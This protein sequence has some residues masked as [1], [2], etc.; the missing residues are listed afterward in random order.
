MDINGNLSVDS[1]AIWNN[2]SISGDLYVD[3]LHPNSGKPRVCLDQNNRLTTT[4]C[5]TRPANNG[6]GGGGEFS[7]SVCFIADTKILM[8]D[9]IYKNIQDV[10]IGD[11][12][13]GETTNN[14][15]LAFHRPEKS[16]GVIYGF[17]GEKAFVTAEHPFKTTQGWK[18]INPEKT[19]QENIGITV[20]QLSV[21]DTLVTEKGN[22]YL[23]SIE[24]E[25]VSEATPLYN[26]VLTGDRTYFADGYLVH[27]KSVCLKP[28]DTG[29]K[30]DSCI[31]TSSVPYRLV[32]GG[33]PRGYVEPSYCYNPGQIFFQSPDFNNPSYITN[34]GGRYLYDGCYTGQVNGQ[35]ATRQCSNVA[36]N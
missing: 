17:N 2:A 32:L 22:V 5:P 33:D 25:K 30:G 20:T 16:E 4:D 36:P 21:G 28:G 11:V 18:S 14:K 24:N 23:T 31:D 26:F 29:Y 15:V 35:P 10:Q 1:L 12:L 27:N 13:K 19:R 7:F 9:G 6:G 3:D 34:C 8:A